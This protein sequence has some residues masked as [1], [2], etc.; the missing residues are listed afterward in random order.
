MNGSNIVDIAQYRA[1]AS[2]PAGRP[3]GKKRAQ[4]SVYSRN[5]K[6]WVDFRYLGHRVREPSGLADTQLNRQRVR[7]QLNLIM[8]EIDNGIFEFAK[9]FAH[10][11]RK[12]YFAE[13]E[14]RTVTQDPTEVCFADYLKKWWQQMQP[15]MSAGMM[16]DYTSIL[17][18]SLIPYFGNL[19]FSEL[20]PMRMKTF[21]AELKGRKTRGGKPL[22]AKR[23][24]NI[25]IPLRV[26]VR[27]A[28]SQYGWSDFSDPF[29]ALKLAKPRKTTVHP[30]SFEQWQQLV[31]ALPAWYRNYFEFA[32]QTGLRPSE[33][34]ALKWTAI[35]EQ[36]IHIE[37][38]RVRNLE[39]EELKTEDS[40]RRVQIRP[41]MQAVLSHQRQ[42]CKHFNSAYVF[43]TP[44]GGPI[45]QDKLYAIWT[46]ALQNA[47]LSHRRMYETR[48]T[49]ASW[50]LAAGESPEWV[51]RTLGHVNTAMVYRTY[52]RY[53]PNLT[54]QDGSAFERLYAQSACR[55][56]DTMGHKAGHNGLPPASPA[57]ITV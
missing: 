23:I 31:A 36:F 35:D 37:L 19:A 27:D 38:S 17:N 16:R 5:G 43:V 25:M 29:G 18:S 32:V 56:P 53:I 55:K 14:G 51:A 24:Q 28:I 49:F 3:R 40:R 15:G 11:K 57:A 48:H 21:V 2:E 33:Q 7:R 8:A 41:G 30:F 42:Q 34:V 9:R 26:I 4:G 22:S 50:A 54:R 45:S 47:G 6:L 20:T 52:G 1:P 10:S 44:Q 46:R 12:Q 13:L 39:K